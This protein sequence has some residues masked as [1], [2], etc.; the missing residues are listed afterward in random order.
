[1]TFTSLSYKNKTNPN[2]FR[3]TSTQ[4]NIFPAGRNTISS[5]N[6][7]CSMSSNY[8]NARRITIRS[9]YRKSILY[10]SGIFKTRTT[11]G[12]IK[13]YRK[14]NYIPTLPPLQPSRIVLA[15]CFTSS[16]KVDALI[17]GG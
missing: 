6:I 12:N 4:Y 11:F 1:M 3:S 7:L 9:Y 2:A 15:F 13:N 17:P 16:G 5:F 8:F 10:C 14:Q